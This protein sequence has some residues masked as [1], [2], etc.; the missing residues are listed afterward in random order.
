MDRS[1]ETGQTEKT[2]ETGEIEGNTGKIEGKTGKIEGTEYSEFLHYFE[3]DKETIKL[4][5]WETNI[6]LTELAEVLELDPNDME[7]IREYN[8]ECERFRTLKLALITVDATA[9]LS[10]VNFDGTLDVNTVHGMSKQ[11]YSF[12]FTSSRKQ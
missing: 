5:L 4:L 10:T 3:L 8:D 9:N 12:D 2:G 11:K 6:K 1:K 7:L